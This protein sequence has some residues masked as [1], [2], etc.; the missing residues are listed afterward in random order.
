VSR[1]VIWRL[2]RGH[3]DR[4]TIT[5]LVRV[6]AALEARVDVRV[7]WHGENLDRLID[8]HHAR[9]VELMLKRLARSG[10]L[11]ATEVSFN[12]RGER[13]SIDILAFHATSS[14]LL[15]IEV[16]SVVPDLQAMLHGIDR[17]TR[18]AAGLAPERGWHPASVSRL[19]VL[20]NDKTAR[21]RVAM[22]RTTF[23]AAAPARTLE[24]RRW[25]REPSG[26]ISGL[27]FVSDA[28]HPGNRP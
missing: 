27:V 19:L 3:A 13:G 18:L 12:V 2:E 16:K 24:V 7:L 20:P 14:A 6:A 17:K 5:T 4:V 28:P 15:V 22:H 21:R 26:P 1:S 11:A 8:A 9:I 10:W 25:L 23:D